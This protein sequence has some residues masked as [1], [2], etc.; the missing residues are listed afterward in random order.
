MCKPKKYMK[1][2]NKKKIKM[3][4]SLHHHMFY[5]I[6]LLAKFLKISLTILTK[7]LKF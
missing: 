6:K 5:H 2:K 7:Y 1:F 3:F 4:A